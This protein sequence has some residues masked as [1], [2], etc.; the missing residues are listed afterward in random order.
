MFGLG[1]SASFSDSFVGSLRVIYDEIHDKTK[2]VGQVPDEGY[3]YDDSESVID[4][5]WVGLPLDEDNED[6]MTDE[7]LASWVA[8]LKKE[9][10]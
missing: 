5:L 7:R 10:V 9:F 4:G 3:T 2:I 6:D 1:D 8:N